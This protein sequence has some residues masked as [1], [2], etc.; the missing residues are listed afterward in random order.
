MLIRNQKGELIRVAYTHC[1][2]CKRENYLA[3]NLTRGQTFPTTPQIKLCAYCHEPFELDFA[4]I[5]PRF[6]P[7]AI[8]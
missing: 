8:A 2:Y 1:P 5:M 4:A 7:E 3:A 6:K